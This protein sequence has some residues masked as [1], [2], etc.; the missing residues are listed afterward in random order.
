MYTRM[1]SVTEFFDVDEAHF[2]SFHFPADNF[3]QGVTGAG[4]GGRGSRRRG[5]WMDVNM[6]GE[7]FVF[8]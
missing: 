3:L 2:V 7:L 6:D 4:S 1:Y 5:T 8:F